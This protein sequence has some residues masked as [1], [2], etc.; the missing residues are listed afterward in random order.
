MIENNT[1]N[2]FAAFEMLMEEIEA[3]VDLI[4]KVATMALARRDYDGAH[5]AIEHAAQVTAFRDKTVSLRKEWKTLTVT[6]GGKA[7]EEILPI[8]R[9]NLGRL[10][11]G[12]RTPEIAYYQPILEAL[13]ELGGSAE[14][15]DVVERVEQSMRGVLRQVDYEPLASGTE[16]LRWR[17]T[18]QWARNTM[19][20]EGLLKLDSPRGM[21]EITEAGRRALGKEEKT[22]TRTQ[23]GKV[24][25]EILPV[26]RRNDE[27]TNVTGTTPTTVSILGQSFAVHS[28]RDVLERTMNTIADVRPEKFEQIMQQFPRYVGRDKK[29]FT[30]ARE[31]KNGTSLLKNSKLSHHFV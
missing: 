8:K 12:L 3:E 25:E 17:N 23:G 4:N 18:A 2:V 27:S 7:E 19:V 30:K 1:S 14:M 6:Q 28:W 13:N 22:F 10:Q 11:R 5:K 29:R 24:E 16:M 9:R 21:W 15:N 20:E 26:K 31:L